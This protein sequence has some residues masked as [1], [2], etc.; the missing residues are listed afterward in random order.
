MRRS[1]DPAARRDRRL[2]LSVACLLLA[3]YTATFAGLPDNPD[4]EVEFQTTSALARRGSFALG[5]TPEAEL[6]LATG[7][8]VRPGGPG[9]EGR[10]YSWSG[11]GQ[12]LVA[13]PLY[14]AGAALARL[15]PALE[16]RHAATTH[17]GAPRS[18]YFAH[19]AVGWRNPLL[20]ALTGALVVVAARRAGARRAHAWLAGLSYGLASFAWPQARSTLSDVQATFFLFLA[21]VLWAESASALER[22]GRAPPGVL[23]G[24]GLAL[25]LAFLTRVMTAPAIMVLVLAFLATL[26]RHA[27]R[28]GRF[29]A[30][31]LA[32][33][34]GPALACCAF[35]LWINAR[36]FGDPL[37]SG[38]GAV[39]GAASWLSQPFLPALADLVAAPGGGLLWL[40]PGLLLAPFGFRRWLCAERGAA[41]CAL[42]VSGAVLLSVAAAPVG[43]HGAWTYG[44]RYVLPLLPFLW[45]AVGPA[46]DAA[47]ARAGSRWLARAVLLL[48]LATTLPGVLVEYTTH[49]DLATRAARLAWPDAPGASEADREETRFRR[50]KSD[51]RFAA[52]WAHWRI[53]AWR[54]AGRGEDF[55][56]RELFF[57][58]RDEVLTPEHER[59]RGFAH[60]AW[61]DLRR[62]LGGP[63]WP[64]LLA[65]AVSRALGL[66][67]A[68]VALEPDP[69]GAGAT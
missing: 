40:A 62:R 66:A 39:V 17:F 28:A 32:L 51:W 43:W 37:E 47:A 44:P 61:V 33:G 23:A 21:F 8:N 49:L 7:Y 1:P 6:V 67:R 15:F 25:G 54:A 31:E 52:P 35:F 55:P 46:L 5:G 12:P 45:T 64:I 59:A 41:L 57:L 10:F 42:W 27:R 24:F 20:G 3:A 38:Y 36:R 4:A 9:R 14:A 19:L 68:R 50:I 16:A 69:A 22:D 26:G 11:V 30:R 18:E 29:P 48:G 13:L 63:A 65:A 2:A 60:L 53:L 56:V 34:L 58:D